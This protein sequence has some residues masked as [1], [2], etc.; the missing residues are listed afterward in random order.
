MQDRSDIERTQLSAAVGNPAK[1]F[2]ILGPQP[3]EQNKIDVRPKKG[4]VLFI[5]PQG[6]SKKPFGMFGRDNRL[7]GYMLYMRAFFI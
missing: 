1:P 2:D 5:V 4:F 7:P 3:Q 6:S